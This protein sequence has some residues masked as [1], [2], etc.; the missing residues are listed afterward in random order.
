MGTVVSPVRPHYQGT[1][2]VYCLSEDTDE[3][4]S[5]AKRDIARSKG[6]SPNEIKVLELN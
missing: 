6:F 4:V 5:K 3:V 2:T 1:E